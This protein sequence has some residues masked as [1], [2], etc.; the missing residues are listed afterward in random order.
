[1]ITPL[2]CGRVQ[3]A[4]AGA[5]LWV[6]PRYY[7]GSSQPLWACIFERCFHL[8]GDLGPNNVQH[9][10]KVLFG[11]FQ[12]CASSNIPIA[13]LPPEPGREDYHAV[14]ACQVLDLRL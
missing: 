13:I 2:P 1:M 7:P 3:V 10:C 9:A 6:W 8:M 14:V 12:L 11:A 5:T 4:M